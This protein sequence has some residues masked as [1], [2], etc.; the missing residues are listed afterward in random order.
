MTVGWDGRKS[1]LQKEYA[2]SVGVKRRPFNSLKSLAGYFFPDFVEVVQIL[3]LEPG[4]AGVPE[5]G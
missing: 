5:H 3:L 1:K 4:D 2:A